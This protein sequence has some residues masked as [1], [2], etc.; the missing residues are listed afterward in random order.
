MVWTFVLCR[1]ILQ[2]HIRLQIHGQ[3]HLIYTLVQ[4]KRI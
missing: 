4:G 3:E 2:A 1:K